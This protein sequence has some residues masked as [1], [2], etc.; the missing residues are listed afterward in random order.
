[1]V[2]LWLTTAPGVQ[3]RPTFRDIL[4][5][6]RTIMLSQRNECSGA[7]APEVF[8]R[9]SILG[10]MLRQFYCVWSESLIDRR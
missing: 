10:A 6:H 4:F 5:T 2:I 7:R 1:M 3:K 9:I 8:F